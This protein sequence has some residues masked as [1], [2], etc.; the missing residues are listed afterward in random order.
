MLVYGPRRTG[1][2]TLLHHCVWDVLTS[3]R[4]EAK[5]LL[6]V[7]FQHPFLSTLSLDELLEI[8]R[9]IQGRPPRL[10]LLDEVQRLADWESWLKV[11]ADHGPPL[12][13]IATGSAAVPL[14]RGSRESGAGRWDEVELPPLLFTEYLSIVEPAAGEL[15]VPPISFRVLPA[16]IPGVVDGDVLG[17]Q[18]I[19]EQRFI[20]YLL[21]G[22][23]PG[24]LREPDVASAQRVIREQV[25]E[26]AIGRDLAREIGGRVDDMERLFTYLSESTGQLIN[27]NT[28]SSILG[29]SRTTVSKYVGHLELAGLLWRSWSSSASKAR[30]KSQ[31]KGYVTDASLAAAALWQGEEPRHDPGRL[32]LL[33]E[34]AVAANVRVLA[35]LEGGR[36]QYWRDRKG[37]EVDLYIELPGAQPLALEVKHKAT[38]NSS[39]IDGLK[40]LKTVRPA[41]RAVLLV[42]WKLKD[43]LPDT[44]DDIFIWPIEPF[45]VGLGRQLAKS[46][47]GDGVQS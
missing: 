9:D 36:V 18:T 5:D 32:G 1:K 24:A 38:Y 13:F 33:V 11:V 14:L 45:L 39:F 7:D 6:L 25:V 37:R 12:S 21:A 17:K 47:K 31:R 20:H 10:L 23:F 22:G 28:L 2:T 35:K 40:S 15:V 41:A 19:L 34:T 46:F 8:H 29:L 16:E 44:T 43:K 26:R 4:L 27:E 30:A 3:E 42:P